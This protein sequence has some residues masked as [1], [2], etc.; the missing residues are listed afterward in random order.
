MMKPDELHLDYE[1]V[2]ELLKSFLL[3]EIR[4]F[5]F[6][7]VVVGLS[8]GIDSAVVCELAARAFGPSHVLALLMPYRSSS[9]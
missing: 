6:H 7:S 2:E 3:D 5:G 4:K 9:T 1:I 8:G